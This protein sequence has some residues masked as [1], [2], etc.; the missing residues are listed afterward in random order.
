MAAA[1]PDYTLGEQLGAGAFELVLAGEHPHLARPVAIRVVIAE[2]PE[3]L[4]VDFATEAR[5]LAVVT[6]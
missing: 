6:R 2:A 1:L 3:G 4:T 5:V